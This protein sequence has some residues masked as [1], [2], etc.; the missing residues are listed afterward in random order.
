M[1]KLS[2]WSRSGISDK[3]MYIITMISKYMAASGSLMSSLWCMSHTIKRIV[4]SINRNISR[5]NLTSLSASS[6]CS[7]E[8]KA[9]STEEAVM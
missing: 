1:M 8:S 2:L 3:A 5:L 9:L 6:V 4:A 7:L